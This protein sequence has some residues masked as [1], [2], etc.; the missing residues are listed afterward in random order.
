MCMVCVSLFVLWS[1][2][3]LSSTSRAKR[4]TCHCKCR[5]GKKMEPS[6]R[7]PQIPTHTTNA[8]KADA[9]TSAAWARR[10]NCRCASPKFQSP[11][12]Q[13]QGHLNLSCLGV[14]TKCYVVCNIYTT[15]YINTGHTHTLSRCRSDCLAVRRVSRTTQRRNNNQGH[16]R[17]TRQCSEVRPAT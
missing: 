14:V 12:P 11:I 4:S 17:T 3:G 9:I 7:Q 15:T 8:M 5:I 10:W 13:M 16:D 6:V 2:V 1:C